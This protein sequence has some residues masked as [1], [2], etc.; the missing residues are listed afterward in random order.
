VLAAGPPGGIPP[1]LAKKPYGLPPGQAK[2]MWRRG[3]LL[4]SAY[5]ANAHYYIVQPQRYRLPPAPPGQRWVLVEDD[6]YL[7]HN[8][9]GLITNVI[10]NAVAQLIR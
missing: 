10:A 6:A 7:V 2:K 8:N 9:N 3:E 1:G 4:P 5:Y